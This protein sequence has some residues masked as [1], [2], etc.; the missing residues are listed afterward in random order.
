MA[1]LETISIETIIF[2]K[3]EGVLKPKKSI[4]F[5]HI[6]RFEPGKK[7]PKYP[8]KYSVYLNAND[9]SFPDDK[10]LYLFIPSAN[11]SKKVSAADVLYVGKAEGKNGV[12]GRLA[13]YQSNFIVGKEGKGRHSH[14]VILDYYSQ[15]RKEEKYIHI[16]SVKTKLISIKKGY[17][18]AE[19]SIILPFCNASVRIK[20]K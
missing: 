1:I 19:T 17:H 14:H 10:G 5:K 13:K 16:Y 6:G 18:D 9:G 2:Y 20:A 8:K 4:E 7:H 11:I 12:K 15:R 3:G